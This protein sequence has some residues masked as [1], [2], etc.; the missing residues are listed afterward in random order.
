MSSNSSI[1]RWF[2][3]SLGQFHGRRQR[4]QR[5]LLNMRMSIEPLEERALLVQLPGVI[6][7][8]TGVNSRN[9]N[10][11]VCDPCECECDSEGGIVAA[12]PDDSGLS[13]RLDDGSISATHGGLISNSQQ[14]PHPSVTFGAQ[15]GGYP[16]MRFQLASAQIPVQPAVFYDT[17]AYVDTDIFR[18]TTT[19]DATGAASGRY[20]VSVLWSALSISGTTMLSG[21]VV[22]PV[23]VISRASSPYGRGRWVAGVDQLVAEPGGS[24]SLL[25]R[26]DGSSAWFAKNGTVYASPEGR[27][28]QLISDSSVVTNGF[29]LQH[30]DGTYDIFNNAGQHVRQVDRNGNFTSFSYFATGAIQSITDQD[31]MTSTFSYTGANGAGKLSKITDW[32]G[33]ETTYV[34]DTNATGAL[35]SIT[36]P[37]PDG[38]GP[39]TPSALSFAYNAVSGLLQN[40]YEPEGR[41]TSI[42][43]D[44][45]RGAKSITNSDT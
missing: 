25:I 5:R 37:D 13:V 31:G 12:T 18:V 6:A 33:R 26:S 44:A 21:S 41:T 19:L 34:I 11:P 32:A 10:S 45:G 1:I 17:A 20:Y 15:N 14:N 24:G 8:N 39:E 38:G 4:H 22:K 3:S 28:E 29:K 36:M 16:A 27:F 43:Y 7:D 2:G 40:I 35:Q 9:D 30:A 23:D 42:L